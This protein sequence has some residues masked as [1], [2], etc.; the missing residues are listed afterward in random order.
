MNRLANSA[1]VNKQNSLRG[2]GSNAVTQFT[3]DS[4]NKLNNK[5]MKSMSES[6]NNVLSAVAS[7]P[8][9]NTRTATAKSIRGNSIHQPSFQDGFFI[10]R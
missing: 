1:R 7:S 8:V 9:A 4:L 2:L 5:E 10:F 3:V 6:F